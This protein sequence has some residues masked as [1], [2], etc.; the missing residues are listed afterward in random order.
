MRTTAV[1]VLHAGVYH[2]PSAEFCLVR[3]VRRRGAV[4]LGYDLWNDYARVELVAVAPSEVDL[5]RDEV[6][7]I[8]Y[9]WRD[10]SPGMA[11]LWIDGTQVLAGEPQPQH[12][13]VVAIHRPA[14]DDGLWTIDAVQGRYAIDPTMMFDEVTPEL[15]DLIAAV[16][17]DEGERLR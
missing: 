8:T 10:L 6:P 2:L 15:A 3:A 11:M 7:G 13:D 1:P 14:A 16:I 9:V 4:V 17:L 5:W 12:L